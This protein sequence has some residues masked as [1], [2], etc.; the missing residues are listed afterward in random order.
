[1]TESTSRFHAH[2]TTASVAAE[3][4]T[5]AGTVHLAGLS[6]GAPACFLARL[7]SP[8]RPLLLIT[9]SA[10][11][12]RRQYDEL[13]FFA[14]ASGQIHLFPAWEIAPYDPL[15]P[16]GEIEAV[17][18]ATLRA[19]QLGQA[20]AVV[21][22]AAALLQRLIPQAVLAELALSLSCGA[23]YGRELLQQRFLALGYRN[24][25][26]VEDRGTFCFRGDLLDVF[27]PGQSQ[28]LRMEFFGD[29]LERIRPFDA[30][31]Q[32][33]V[34]CDLTAV[35]LVPARE[36]VLQGELLE[37]FCQRL[38]QRCDDLGLPRS[39]REAVI[40]EAREGLLA[41]GRAFL[42]PLNYDR[43]E[44]LFDYLPQARGVCFDPPAIEQAIDS[45]A[46]AIRSG[47]ERAAASGEPFVEPHQ[48][49]LAPPEIEQ[50]LQQCRR[51]DL[52]GLQLLDDQHYSHR[53]QMIC[54]GNGAFLQVPTAQRIT[55]L[56]DQL[57]QWQRERWRVLLVCHQPGALERLRDLLQHRDMVLSCRAGL[58]QDSGLYG[59]LGSVR[60][61]VLPDERLALVS[62]EEI[63]GPRAR[64]NSRREARAKAVLSSLARL[65]EGDAVVHVDHGIG[66]YR[67]LQHLV[68]GAVE[69]DF[70][71]L[72]YA[73]GD[74]LYVPT[75]RIEKV[76]KYS[77]AEGAAVR[78]DKMGGNAW[79]KTC[80]RARA[81]V[82][83]MAR[84]L[85]TLY[86]RRQMHRAQPFS[87]P[88]DDFRAFEAAFP[89]EET[90]DQLAAINDVL[91][92][93]QSE[94]PMDRLICGD[95]G[96]GKTEVA[97]RAAFK[98]ALD[99]RQV[100]VV[101]P[102][103]VLAR[104]HFTTFSERLRDYPLRVEMVSR[105]RTPA[106]I[107]QVLTDLVAGQ[108]D[109]VIGTH[110]LLQRDVRFKDLGL[111]VIDEEQRF[112]VSHK[113]RLKKL[114]AQVAML[115]LS[116]TPIPRTL[117][118]GLLG[119]RDLSLID[120]PP[121]DRLA[122]RTYVTRFD[123]DLIREAILR[124]LQRGGQVYFVHNRVQSIAAMERLLRSLVPEARIAV[125]HGQMA[126]KELEQVLLDFIEGRSQVLLCSTIIENG[127]DI[128]RANTI[129]INRADCFGLAQLYQLRGRVGRGK[130]RGYAYLLIPGEAS[131]TRE[132]RARLQVLQELTELGA[133]FRVASYD[134]ELR[135]AGDLLGARQAGQMAA[136]GFEMYTELL[137]ETIAELKGAEHQGRIDPEIRLGLRAFLP[138]NYV[139][140]PNQRLVFYKR[141][142]AAEDEQGLYDLVDELQDRYGALPPAAE[143]LLEMMKLR[144]DLKRLRIEL[145]EYDGRA[146]VFGFHAS[147]PVA[148]DN[149]LRLLQEDPRRYSLS[150]DYR[151]R[152]VTERLGDGELL[153]EARKQLQAFC[154]AC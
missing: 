149:L 9:A 101:V 122:V 63:F 14:P 56:V 70:L 76:Q 102:T 54:R 111:V 25:P 123:E 124:E 47:A 117:N 118:M 109:I 8:A 153:A 30:A 125:G 104:Q 143:I 5:S 81:A 20:Q 82:E 61:F 44:T 154:G 113:E 107:R 72:E 48:L 60:G 43:L 11:E 86:A 148:P 139:A 115:T 147:T 53:F 29:R 1:M 13:C 150:P 21:T 144:V 93:M 92:D 15:Q 64:R 87:P 18:L 89:Y 23:D 3:L 35:E 83:E 112:G 114:R 28:P 65:Q 74:R 78:L 10:D 33:S 110:R 96:F 95:V 32:R 128:P 99:G 22:T 88:D 132:A 116:A 145:A 4:A 100:A 39:C 135:G 127:L 120:T 7:L 136:I 106:Q 19:I 45:Q 59:C 98:A 17:R 41:P 97:I 50:R 137:E 24:V 16:H 62:E 103:T 130:E 121:V 152:V 80:Q 126:E 71:L 51:I 90:P 68:S 75:E 108:V 37:G 52:G 119:M 131:L 67:G 36:M 6:G 77:G 138:E 58:P 85:L 49:Y 133:G 69:G 141:L 73:G 66:I 134:L 27:A 38:K 2:S 79:E 31:S 140:D 151:L 146:L 40:L 142:A 57:Q 105:F 84:E 26:L 34:D 55:L 91:A 42:L 46:Q 94:V 129:L 12:A